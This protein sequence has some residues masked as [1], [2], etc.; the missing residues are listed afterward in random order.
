MLTGRPVS[1]ATAMAP[2][3]GGRSVALKGFYAVSM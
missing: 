3:A 2:E 1:K